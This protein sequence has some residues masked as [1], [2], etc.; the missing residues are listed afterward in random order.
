[1]EVPPV[2]PPATSPADGLLPP[3]TVLERCPT[4]IEGLDSILE[5]GIPRGNMVLVAGSVGT[6]KTTLCLEFLV[7]GAERGE[8]SLFLSVTEA[9][10]KLIQNLS[11]F[12]FFHRDLVENGS[13]VFVDLPKVYDRLGLGREEMTSEEIGIL[14]RTIRDLVRSLGIQRL[15]LDSLTSVCYR[16]RREEQIRDFML[17]LGQE[18]KEAGCTSLL[19][20]EIGPLPGRYSLH[21][22]EEAIVDGVILLSNIHRMGDILR[23]LQIIKMRGTAHSQAQFVIQ[24]TPIGILMAP[25]LK[26]GREA[27]A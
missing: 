16:I 25:H 27:P 26:G 21:G 24:L 6:G 10:Q 4:G 18:L 22:V 8:R 1:M 14:L 3:A 17:R 19:V 12:E 11:T 7:R 23:V 13:L 2:T 9:S 20:S 15:V 5:G